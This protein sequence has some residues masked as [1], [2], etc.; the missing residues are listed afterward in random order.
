MTSFDIAEVNPA[1]DENN[2]TATLAALLVAEV[3]KKFNK[4]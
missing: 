3:M 4:K 1:V 2:K